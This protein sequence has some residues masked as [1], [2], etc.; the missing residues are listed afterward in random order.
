[1]AK[2]SAGGS[3]A[4]INATSSS[5]ELIIDIASPMSSAPSNFLYFTFVPLQKF[6]L[7]LYKNWEQLAES[8]CIHNPRLPA[9]PASHELPNYPA[10]ASLQLRSTVF[11]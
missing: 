3:T 5:L 8:P 2:Q 1:M 6:L 4:L 7:T 10:C 11:S 9:L